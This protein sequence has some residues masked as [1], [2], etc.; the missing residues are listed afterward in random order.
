[1]RW[2]ALA[3]PP[4]ILLLAACAPVDLDAP[5]PAFETG[6]D[7]EAWA[8]VP[9]GEFLSGQQAHPTTIDFDYELMVTDV[10]VMQYLR[11]LNE[12]IADSR[13]RI[14]DA[15]VVGFYPGD[16]FH[17][18]K[19]EVEIAPGDYVFVPLDDPASRFTFDGSTFAAKPSYVESPD[20]Q[21]LLVRRLGPPRRF[22]RTIADP[23]GVG[24]GGPGLG[25]RSSVPMGLQ[26]RPR[27]RELDL[28]PRSIEDMDPSAPAQARSVLQRAKPR[29]FCHGRLIEPLRAV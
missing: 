4:L 6:V 7:P 14:D 22:R 20:D 19:H 23:V 27:V 25:R 9:A 12:A 18:V 3:G 17:G 15:Q 1:M 29:R 13:L 8:L 21:C 16:E 5:M 28:E 11:F 24:E 26:N 2:L 10:T